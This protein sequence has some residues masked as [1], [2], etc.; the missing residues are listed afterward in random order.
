MTE[1]FEH[2]ELDAGY[3]FMSDGSRAIAPRMPWSDSAFHQ[4]MGFADWMKSPT[5]ASLRAGI[6]APPRR[7]DRSAVLHWG[8]TAYILGPVE[9]LRWAESV[10][11]YFEA[12][13]KPLNR[14][15]RRVM[16]EDVLDKGD[17]RA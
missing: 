2:T 1:T 16:L 7:V 6:V 10:I 17:A 15:R 3:Q 14:A 5:A 8:R 4:A 9:S 11:A 13:P 12:M